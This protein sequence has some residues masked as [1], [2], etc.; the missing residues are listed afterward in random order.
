MRA[1]DRRVVLGL[2]RS[3]HRREILE[4]AWDLGVRHVD[5]AFSY[6]SF[7][8]HAML[9]EV[10]P[11]MVGEFVISTKVGFFPGGEHSLEPDRLRQ[12]AEQS[13]AD[14]GR[15]PDVL[16]LHNPEH[17]LFRMEREKAS[18]L[19]AEA[20]GALAGVSAS[21]LAGRW[22]IA[23]WNPRH[24]APLLT[25]DHPEPQVVMIRCGLTVGP[26][27]LEAAED[28]RPKTDSSADSM[29][30]MAPFAGNTMDAMWSSVRTSLFVKPGQETS[31]FQAAFGAAFHLPP[32]SRVAVGA[33]NPVHLREL[34]TATKF[35]IDTETLAAYLSLI[36]ERLR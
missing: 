13:A 5:T 21:G 25:P 36:R 10:A 1:S 30:G 11:D 16:L 18:D 28:L 4:A 7:A 35:D 9:A 2:Y 6:C 27:T 14:L 33:D 15:T 26:E 34:V 19:L 24:L 31:K 12:A 3:R 8:S 20:T 32:V 23:S 17:G 29:W 22:G